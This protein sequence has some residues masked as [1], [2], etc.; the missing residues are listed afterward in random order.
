MDINELISIC[1]KKISVLCFVDSPVPLAYFNVYEE[2]DIWV[3]IKGCEG[4][5]NTSRCCGKCPM[6]S[7]KGCFLHLDNML[8]KPYRCV[9]KPEPQVCIIWCQLEFQC[10]KGPKKGVIRRV[11]DRKAP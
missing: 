10:V 5:I 8:N 3:K 4:C 2:G 1:N 6:L 7:E 9:V 11:S